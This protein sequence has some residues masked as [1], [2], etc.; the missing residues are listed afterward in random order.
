MHDEIKSGLVELDIKA[1]QKRKSIESNIFIIIGLAI[2]FFLIPYFYP[3]YTVVF[4]IDVLIILLG[5]FYLVLGGIPKLI[6][7]LEP[8]Y[9]AFRKIAQAIKVLEESKK[10]VA[11]EE[12]HR[13][14]ERAYETL[15]SISLSEDIA[16]YKATNDIFK[17]F[18]K[19]LEL[20]VLPAIGGSIIKIEHLEEIALAIY[21]LDPAKLDA[22]NK[23]LESSYNIK[24]LAHLGTRDL[25]RDFIRS[26]STLKVILVGSSFII[27]CFVFYFAVVSYSDIPKGY[28]LGASVALFIGLLGIYFR[29]K[30]KGII[31]RL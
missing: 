25:V 16:W 15:N 17:K 6:E 18:L 14:V 28:V 12:A 26:H 31:Y 9:S 4:A 13:D 20:I 27:G 23:K 21:S 22:V 2:I 5:G 11:Y 19:D 8:E 29:G 3:Q 30:Q 10:D 24:I 1:R 7:P